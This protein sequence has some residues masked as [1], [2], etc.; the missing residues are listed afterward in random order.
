MRVS[1]GVFVILN[2]LWVLILFSCSNYQSDLKVVEKLLVTDPQTADSVLMS[3]PMPKSQRDNALYAI[4]K[5]QIDYELGR[6]FS[7]DSLIITATDYYGSRR[8]SYHAALAWYSQGCV[9][10]RMK[11]NHAAIYA[12]LK[13][14]DLFPDTLVRYYALT[15]R[16][17][18]S[19]YYEKKMY[20]CAY[21]E[22]YKCR[23][24]ADRIQD[25]S[26]SHY[27]SVFSVLSR[28]QDPNIQNT[29]NQMS[30]FSFILNEVYEAENARTDTLFKIPKDNSS[31]FENSSDTTFRVVTIKSMLLHGERQS[32]Q[33]PPISP[34]AYY[35]MKA[36]SFYYS[37][38]FDSAYIFFKKSIPDISDANARIIIYDRLAE[39]SAKKGNA[40]EVLMWHQQY[41]ELRDSIE[42]VK[43]SDS[44]EIMDLQYLHREELKEEKMQGRH[45]RFVLICIFSF[46]AITII[47]VLIY[48]L[49][50]NREKKR[51]IEKQEEF[52]RLEQEIRRSSI[53]I[54]ESRVREQSQTD[55]EA[56]AVLMN[57]YRHRIEINKKYFYNSEAFR[58]LT[59]D[60]LGQELDSSKKAMVIETIRHSFSDTI[61]DM[62]IEY[63]GIDTEESLTLL[64]SAMHFKNELVAKLL[65]N[66]TADA[67]RKRKY[68]F[69]KRNPDYYSLFC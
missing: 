49:F 31:S 17:L 58:T 61:A 22:F 68:R 16:N 51:I 64:L 60:S 1:G 69:S 5:T 9:Y 24:N 36:T 38:D 43:Q 11:N 47:T 14:K 6:P 4:L 46:I 21:D 20:D 32:N 18:G 48:V 15:E 62:Q 65:G 52:I 8:K 37:E 2:I 44:R 66:V 23:I 26:L 55:P 50:K 34:D 13:A 10:S 33:I 42:M 19:R 28:I 3:L 30:Q 63:P 29:D 40:A 57:L 45:K 39:I 56:R 54:L 53:F 7:S 12:Y 27:A 59:S 67:I 41:S 35:N 25:S